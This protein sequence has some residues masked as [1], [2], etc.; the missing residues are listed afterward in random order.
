VELIGTVVRLQ[1]QV[2]SL[3]V[4]GATREQYDPAGLRSVPALELCQAGA[5][6]RDVYGE[7]V[8]DQHHREQPHSKNRRGVNGVSIGFTVYYAAMRER[9]GAHLCD[10]I[11]GENIVVATEQRVLP[12]LA[13]HG[14]CIVPAEGPEVRLENVF[15]AE[16]CVP[17]TRFALRYPP[18]ARSNSTVKEA[19]AFLREGMRGYY[20]T[21]RGAP[22]TLRLGD[23]VYSL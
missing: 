17:F 7:V 5:S 22:V 8:L 21:Y 9:F 6:S 15:A 12:D 3:K 2:A 20:A 10:G 13:A 19:L 1:V 18:E 4:Q 16:P 14:L 23:R 11:A